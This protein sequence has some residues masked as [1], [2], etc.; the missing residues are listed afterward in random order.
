LE[1]KAMMRTRTL[2]VTLAGLVSLSGC[3]GEGSVWSLDDPNGVPSPG[4]IT[5]RVCA[6]TGRTWLADALA[7]TYVYDDEGMIS[8][9]RKA[10]SDRDGY[11]LLENL[12]GQTA[13]D[14]FVQSGYEIVDRNPGVFVGSGEDVTL[15]PPKCFDPLQMDVAVIMGD[16]DDFQLVLEDLGFANFELIQPDEI[17]DFLLDL[18]KM[19][20]FDVIFFNGG[21]QEEDIIYDTDG[22]LL[23]DGTGLTVPDQVMSNVR[24]YV[25]GGGTIY[26]SDWAYD[27]VEIGWPEQI[28]FIGDDG[29][30]NAAQ[31]GEYQN[32]NAAVSDAAL[33]DFL[34]TRHI[35][36]QY[37]LPVWPPIENAQADVSIHMSAA[38]N[39]RLGTS[40]YTQPSSPIL[41][42]FTGGNGKVVYST[43]RVAENANDDMLRSLQYMLYNL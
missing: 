7:Y 18:E 41:V 14:V 4:S 36:I 25:Q 29:T 17:G 12:P 21:H 23:P 6:P 11:W 24:T 43:F 34:G 10:Y 27:V 13:Y 9:T 20:M 15:D 8:D 5:G 35:N 3:P 39:Y 19:Q 30:P 26:A 33:A 28:N 32:V 38:V 16:Y 31:S 40:S 22:S 1:S 37:D 2:V 42:S